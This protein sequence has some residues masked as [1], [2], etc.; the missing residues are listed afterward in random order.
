MARIKL[1][2]LGGGSTRAVGTMASFIH[3]GADFE[4]S[5]IVLIDLPGSRLDLV[6][7]LADKMIAARGLDMTVTTTTDRRAGLTDVDAVLSSFRPG[8]FQA[9]VLDEKIPL[10]HGVIG[11]ETQG[12]GGFFMCLRAVNVMMGV[13]DD[14][15][16]VAPKAKVFNYTNPVNLVAQAWT[17]HCD[18]PLVALCEGPIVYPRELMRDLGYVYDDVDA[19][20]V[21]LNHASWA[22]DQT[23]QGKDALPIL[24]EEWEKRRDDPT[25]DP[26]LLRRLRIA[27]T[28]NAIPS[29]YFQYY[30]CEDEVVAELKAKPTSRAE[31]ILSWAPGYWEHYEEQALTDDPQLDPARSRGGI[32]ELERRGQQCAGD[33]A[34]PAPP[35]AR[36]VRGLVMALGEYQA[37]AGHVAWEG[38]WKAG[39]RT[40]ASNPLVRTIEKAE[41]IYTELAAAHREHL[42]ERL[43]P[44]SVR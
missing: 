36:D 9:R 28:F 40:L 14:L 21:G 5:E 20:M 16:A 38:D 22:F 27:T 26:D 24:R 19:K 12:P 13:A 43:I 6:K 39:I 10:K 23:Y 32:H 30:Y 31:D 2:Y 44:P 37:S 34:L 41:V 17:T 11:Q 8:G 35:L 33:V 29:H 7:T 25:Q 4:G 1:A 15:A 42:P 18:I 3:Q